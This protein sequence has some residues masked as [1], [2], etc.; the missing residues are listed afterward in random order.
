MAEKGIV[1]HDYSALIPK[2]RGSFHLPSTY[3]K[4]ERRLLENAPDRCTASGTRNY[5]IILL[6][7]RL[8]IRNGDIA[9]LTFDEVLFEQDRNIFRQEKTKDV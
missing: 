7:N 8:G 1:R 3:E 5:A 9:G 6:A 2:A 4:S